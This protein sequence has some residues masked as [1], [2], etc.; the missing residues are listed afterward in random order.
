MEGRIHRRVLAYGKQPAATVLADFQNG[1]DGYTE[2][3]AA[4]QRERYGAPEQLTTGM[5]NT[6]GYRLGRAFAN[7]FT[8]TL[9]VLAVISYAADNLLAGAA[10]RSGT[11]AVVLAVMLVISGIIRFVQEVRAKGIVDHL[12]K[13]VA[14]DVTVRRNGAWAAVPATELVVGDLVRFQAGETVP[15]DLRLVQTGALFISQAALNGE[16]AVI[17]KRSDTCEPRETLAFQGSVVVGG[18]GEGIVL[19][20]GKETAYGDLAAMTRSPYRGFD[21]GARAIAWVLIRFMA[22][23]VP[24]VFIACGVTKGDWLVS[25][26]FALS[27][28]V[29]LMPE[30]LPM[31]S[32]ACLAKG[33]V[34]ME[35]QQTIVRNVNAMQALGSLDV[36]CIDK[37]GTLTGDTVQL[38][39]YLDILGNESEQVLD[40]A[41]L[42]S[43][44][45]T[46]VRNHLDQAIRKYT[47]FPGKEGHFAKLVQEFPKRGEVPFDYERKYVSVLV[48]GETD[49]L[50]LVKGNI[51]AVCRRCTMA[52]YRGQ[53]VPF[54]PSDMTNVHAV[55]DDLLD[56]GMKGLAV[57]YKRLPKGSPCTVAAEEGLTLVGYL[58]FFDAPKR[59]AARAIEKLRNL[60]VALK[61]LTGDQLA[62]AVSVCRRLGLGTNALTG[63]EIETLSQDELEKRLTE[64]TIFAEVSPPQK[65]R[66]VSL[67]QRAGHTV[68]FL[69]DGLNDVPAMLTADVGIS[70]H[71]AVPAAQQSASVILLQKELDVLERSILEG[72]KAFANMAKYIK[73]T[74]S[75]NFGNIFSIVIASVLLPFLPMA[76]VQLVLLNVLYD[77]LCLVLPWDRVDAE[78]YARPRPWTGRHLGRFMLFFG[79]ISSLFDLATFIF[80]Y[81]VLCPQQVGLPFAALSEGARQTHFI[82]LFQT[83]WFLES[84]WT[85]ILILHFVR[86]PRLPFVQSRPAVPV[87]A[88]TLCGIA[89]FTVLTF[90]PGGAFLGLTALPGYYFAFL[91]LI[92]GLYM[93]AIS[94]AKKYYVRTYGS[95]V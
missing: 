19:A 94:L 66:I 16:S 50:L 24:V 40:Y 36:L 17:S 87:L 57:A 86:T 77:V 70:V 5:R 54:R 44:Y 69:G 80:L 81:V 30:L 79:P 67:L 15:A 42:N 65:A 75:S 82:A 35:R 25:F 59:S 34:T 55:V 22:V 26:V 12:A 73:A 2:E 29:G 43:F 74:A 85:Q 4:A 14:T 72:R 83:G 9:A 58:G 11:M 38:E 52:E 60:H 56:D 46:G 48:A 71:N 78:L 45:H 37:T 27:V 8:V 21:Q 6:L 63:A 49:D 7:P 51:E 61:V 93:V 33:S 20:V 90:T 1:P 47:Y 89:A 62:V 53:V 91:V 32:M 68:G 41:Y 95:L 13:L 84:L 92:V 23:L 28:A 18:W 64:V 3:Q 31:V 39:Y 10:G 76:S 88:V